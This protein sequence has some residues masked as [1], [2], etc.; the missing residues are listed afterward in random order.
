MLE[1]IEFAIIVLL[2]FLLFKPEYVK[3]LASTLGETVAEFKKPTHSKPLTDK[4]IIWIAE[5]LGI[6]VEGKGADQLKKEIIE[7]LSSA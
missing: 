5:L 6:E 2:L 7:K 4:E 3:K 1:Y